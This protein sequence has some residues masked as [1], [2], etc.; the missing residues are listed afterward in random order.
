MSFSMKQIRKHKSSNATYS[1]YYKIIEGTEFLTDTLKED[2]KKYIQ[3][4]FSVSM[5]SNFSVSKFCNM[6]TEWVT[7][8]IPKDISEINKEDVEPKELELSIDINLAMTNKVINQLYITNSIE[9][10]KPDTKESDDNE[11]Q[12]MEMM[13]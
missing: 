12:F 10:V 11:K 6:I 3:Y 9:D 5:R 7:R 4:R 13:I 1:D 8:R 2:L